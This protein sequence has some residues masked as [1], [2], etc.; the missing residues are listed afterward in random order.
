MTQHTEQKDQIRLTE[1]EREN[2]V[3]VYHQVVLQSILDDSADMKVHPEM[4]TM[5]TRDRLPNHALLSD[6]E[7]RGRWD[8][9]TNLALQAIQDDYRGR[10]IDAFD[11]VGVGDL[12][13]RARIRWAH[14]DSANFMK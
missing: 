8:I 5:P 7:H 2:K 4:H 3:D 11:K 1:A 12:K 10:C 9:F 14:W 6:E 13:R